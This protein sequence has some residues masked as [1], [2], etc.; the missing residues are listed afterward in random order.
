MPTLVIDDRTSIFATFI[1]KLGTYYNDELT[2]IL[3]T[4]I[5]KVSLQDLES[6]QTL[7]GTC[8][9]YTGPDDKSNNGQIV[10]CNVKMVY[11]ISL[12]ND[13]EVTATISSLSKNTLPSS[14]TPKQFVDHIL[15][16]PYDSLP[17]HQS[18]QPLTFQ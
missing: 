14:S 10:S 2:Q 15:T 1:D 4:N 5:E 11:N 6:T 18:N 12:S 3:L 8:I 16:R 9:T 13:I 7:F 17:L